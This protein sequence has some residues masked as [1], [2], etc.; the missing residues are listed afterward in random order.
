[1]FAL[2]TNDPT[3]RPHQRS[4][5]LFMPHCLASLWSSPGDDTRLR[6]PQ[7]TN[8]QRANLLQLAATCVSRG[9]LARRWCLAA[10]FHRD[11]PPHRDLG[12]S[13]RHAR[14]LW[15]P[16]DVGDARARARGSRWRAGVV[17]CGVPCPAPC[18][19]PP[20][21]LQIC[22]SAPDTTPATTESRAA[23]DGGVCRPALF[24]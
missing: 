5:G 6:H 11:P 3:R 1:M 2:Q 21:S 7:P 12:W 24:V 14:R 20:F 4:S 22:R 17:W 18:P 9:A 15:R 19:A 23:P 13:A 8:C 10:F 16:G